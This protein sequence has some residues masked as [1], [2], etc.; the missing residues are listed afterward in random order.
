MHE[1]P[2]GSKRGKKVLVVDDS[3][4]L[5][6]FVA[7]AI[8]MLGHDVVKAEDPQRALEVLRSQPIDAV[9][10][11]IMMHG[12][13]VGLDLVTRVR[14]DLAPP[15]PPVIACSGFPHFEPEA[16]RRGAWAFLA[17]PFTL[18]HVQEAVEGAL[19]GRPAAPDLVKREAAR[20]RK[21]RSRAA[22]EAETFF[23]DLR[24]RH[25]MF[26]ERAG[27][28]ANWASAYLGVAHAVL[29][30]PVDGNL[31]VTA[32][33]DESV[34]PV[35]AKMDDRL[36]FCRDV[37]ETASSIVLPD[38]AAFTHVPP[39]AKALPLRAFGAVPL[40]W[41]NGVAFGAIAVFGDRPGG[42]DGDD[43]A[44]LEVLGQR[45]SAAVRGES[46]VP[47][48]DSA[49]VLNKES[50]AEL[51]GIEL[52][53]A[54]RCSSFLELAAVVVGRRRR[55][56][57]WVEAISRVTAGRR[58]A[59]TSLGPDELGIYAVA[60]DRFLAA[61]EIASS[62]GD[63]RGLLGIRGAGV[64]AL[65]GGEVPSFGEQALLNV[66]EVLAARAQRGEI[67]RVV[68]RAEPWR[69]SRADRRGAAAL[70]G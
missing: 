40:T 17:K 6:E 41:S 61:R 51:L 68:L 8:E 56:T 12:G 57:S 20:A 70:P 49:G 59:L 55:D 13:P 39:K 46:M 14:S 27:W 26:T 35:G 42:L 9:V 44:V 58:R 19:A 54:R 22:G 30:A 3:E 2:K 7:L 11:D 37:L 47:F 1:A 10:T 21:L 4:D 67:E 28:A 24:S 32:S 65:A 16:L 69:E 29:L 64:V 48:F 18:E 43:L 34:L 60:Q 50:F 63:L 15:V 62:L 33:N 38:A 25:P 36:P 45:A 52:R 23:R 53:R 31:R 66:A 5:R